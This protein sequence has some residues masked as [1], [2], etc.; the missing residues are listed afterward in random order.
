[1]SKRNAK[2]P[3]AGSGRSLVVVESPAKARTIS[4]ILGSEYEVKASV[5]HVRDLPKSDLGVD[6]ESGFQPK[7]VIPREK[8]KAVKEIRQAAAAAATVYLATDP[9]R[10]GEAI[11]WH[12]IEAAALEG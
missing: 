3:S 9:D 10:E 4:G 2:S 11:A 1:V 6:V 12:L 5:G 8:A 7:Y